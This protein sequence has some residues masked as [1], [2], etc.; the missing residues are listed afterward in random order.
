MKTLVIARDIP[1]HQ[2]LAILLSE[3]DGMLSATVRPP[4]PSGSTWAPSVAPDDASWSEILRGVPAQYLQFAKDRRRVY[5]AEEAERAHRAKL[6]AKRE[7]ATLLDRIA[8]CPGHRDSQRE[9]TQMLGYTGSVAVY[10]YTEEN[11]AAHG[12]VTYHE[13]C[14]CGAERAVNANG[15]HREYSPWGAP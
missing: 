7:R 9:G 13:V 8:S 5:L 3:S 2:G 6:A 11:R 4:L 14:R 12:G 10:P 1:C 15:L